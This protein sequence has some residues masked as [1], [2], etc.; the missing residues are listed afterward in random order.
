MKLGI[1]FNIGDTL[2]YCHVEFSYSSVR[3]THRI[4]PCRVK[5]ISRETDGY[6]FIYI[7][8]EISG[9]DLRILSYD[10]DYSNWLFRTEEE[11]NQ[12][13]RSS[14]LNKM[15]QIRSN[16]EKDVKYL[17]NYMKRKK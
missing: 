10:T 16:Y 1:D 2:W 12:Y 11:V 14:F 17:E 13:W 3:V 6:S 5:V 7:T 15:D 4:F 9:K 8:D